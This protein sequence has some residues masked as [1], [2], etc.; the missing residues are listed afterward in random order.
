MEEIWCQILGHDINGWLY[1]TKSANKRY[2]FHISEIVV[3]ICF[4]EK[5][6]NDDLCFL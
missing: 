1:N 4:V 2:S 6:I 3:S 5:D